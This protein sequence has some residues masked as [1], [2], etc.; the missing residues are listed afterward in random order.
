[1][2]AATLVETERLARIRSSNTWSFQLNSLVA[3]L[4]NLIP[5]KQKFLGLGFLLRLI[6][7]INA[8]WRIL[9]GYIGQ[10][11]I[12]FDWLYKRISK[13]LSKSRGKEQLPV[14]WKGL[15]TNSD[16]EALT[17]FLEKSNDS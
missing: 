11:I 16:L 4:L 3:E 17:L 6:L 13:Q 15:K 7:E 5:K 10:R 8:G 14:S 1:M 2:T 12:R 9:E